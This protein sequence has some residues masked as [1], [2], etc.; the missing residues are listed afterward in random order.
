MESH[1][2]GFVDQPMEKKY[3]NP[4]CMID[5]IPYIDDLPKCDQYDDDY[6]IEIEA[7]SSKKSTTCFWDEEVQ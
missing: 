5:D 6:V 7:N 2:N 1:E 3:A 4:M